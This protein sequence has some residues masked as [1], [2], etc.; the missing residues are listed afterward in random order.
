CGAQFRNEL[1]EIL[2]L[3]KLFSKR[4]QNQ[5][6]DERNGSRKKS[7]LA[8]PLRIVRTSRSAQSELNRKSNIIHDPSLDSLI[9][10]PGQ[11]ADDISMIENE[12]QS[13]ETTRY[14]IKLTTV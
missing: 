2:H 5:A 7:S 9:V 12:Q 4:K 3:K 1:I 11:H 13:D 10:G 6:N 8:I 14:L